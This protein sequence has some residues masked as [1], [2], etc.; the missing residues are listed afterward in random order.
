P[1]ARPT[2]VTALDP[3]GSPAVRVVD[4]PPDRG[5]AFDGSTASVGTER[6]DRA[7]ADFAHQDATVYVDVDPAAGGSMNLELS[8][9]GSFAVAAGASIIFQVQPSGLTAFYERQWN[10]IPRGELGPALPPSGRVR[11]RLRKGDG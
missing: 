11:L 1:A 6:L 5:V 3:P 10:T 2:G 7:A 8:S 4:G 9:E